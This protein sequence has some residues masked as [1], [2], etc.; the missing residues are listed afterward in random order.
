MK[1]SISPIKKIFVLALF[2]VVAIAAGGFQSNAAAGTDDD[3]ISFNTAP[4]S[5]FMKIQVVEV[6]EAVANAIVS[7]R[8]ANGSYKTPEDLK[9]VPGMNDDL[10]DMLDPIEEEGDIV[11]EKAGGPGGMNAY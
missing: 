3:F 8:K 1:L 5:D 6:P 9:K 4:A 11:F 2:M 10:Y 7:H